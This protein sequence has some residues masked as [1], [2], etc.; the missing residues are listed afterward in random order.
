MLGDKPVC[1]RWSCQISGRYTAVLP[2][3]N[4]DRKLKK[5]YKP[6]T[7]APKQKGLNRRWYCKL[8]F[9][10]ISS[11]GIALG[12]LVSRIEFLDTMNCAIMR[13]DTLAALGVRVI[14]SF[15]MRDLP[16]S[17]ITSLGWQHA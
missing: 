12:V 5:N 6:S 16:R 4:F 14:Y 13:Y 9:G 1:I 8:G 3:R 11:A 15:V 7:S 17:C 10:I 2:K